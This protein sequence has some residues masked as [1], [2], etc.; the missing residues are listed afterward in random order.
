MRRQAKVSDSVEYYTALRSQRAVERAD[1]AL[2]VCDAA[3]RRHDAG[4]ADRRA[5]DAGGLRDAL[6][7][8]KWDVRPMTED[9]LDHERAKVLR[10]L[11]LRPKVAD[12]QRARA[13]ATSSA[14]SRRRSPSATCAATRIPTP[15]LN[16]FVAEAVDRPASPRPGRGTASSSSTW[17]RSGRAR[18]ASRSRSTTAHR[19]TRDY[20]YF[21]ENRLR[22]RFGL[23]GVPVII[24]VRE[25]KQRRS[26]RS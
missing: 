2:V 25:R 7:L 15:E 17:P 23:D 4:H 9:D 13:G 18:R 11:R 21:I 3:G 22:K 6:V 12:D 19:M 14:C 1:V 26:E 8:N 10:K 16:R 24:D 5:R 20:G